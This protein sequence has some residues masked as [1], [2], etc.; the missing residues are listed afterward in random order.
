[1]EEPVL[2]LPDQTQPFQIESNASKYASGAVLMQTDLVPICQNHSLPPN[3]TMKYT[4]ESFLQLFVL[5]RTGDT[6]SK[7]LLMKLLSILTIK[8]SPT[9][10]TRRN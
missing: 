3:K 4:I 7:D 8:T 10:K 9:S 6:M 2:L 5:Y 1:M